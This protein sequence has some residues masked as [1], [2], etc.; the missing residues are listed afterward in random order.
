MNPL[1]PPVTSL[2]NIPSSFL[3]SNTTHTAVNAPFCTSTK[4]E[5]ARSPRPT[6]PS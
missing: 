6:T 4:R 1:V 3:G 5:T 2:N